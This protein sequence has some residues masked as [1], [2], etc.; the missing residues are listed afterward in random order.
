MGLLFIKGEKVD[1]SKAIK[2][3]RAIFESRKKSRYVKL[4]VSTPP[5]V[6]AFLKPDSTEKNHEWCIS[7]ATSAW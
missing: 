1:F 6:N 3:G 5:P 7:L 2:L 4:H